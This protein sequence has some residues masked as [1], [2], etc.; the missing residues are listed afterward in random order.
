MSSSDI[1]IKPDQF[2]A[3]VDEFKGTTEEISSVKVDDVINV[4]EKTI[5]NSMDEL[6]AIIN[7]F[8]SN[9]EQY[10]TLANKDVAEMNSLK[11][12]WVTKD[13]NLSNEINGN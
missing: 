10:I 2:S 7:T 8:Q 11:E 5:L 12:K 3:E 6:I 9:V 4:N 13:E 1:L